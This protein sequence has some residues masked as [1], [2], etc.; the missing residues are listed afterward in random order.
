MLDLPEPSI[1]DSATDVVVAWA[2]AGSASLLDHFAYIFFRKAP[3]QHTNI[4]DSLNLAQESAQ[5]LTYQTAG[6]ELYI[7]LSAHKPLHFYEKAIYSDSSAV[8]DVV[9]ATR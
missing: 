7:D 4:P 1:I 3:L 9:N 6:Q 5:L 8:A 2:T